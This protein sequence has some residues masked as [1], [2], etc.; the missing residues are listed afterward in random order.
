M[1]RYTG[2]VI[3]LLGC[4]ATVPHVDQPS[5]PPSVII[6]PAPQPASTPLKS[7]LAASFCAKAKPILIAKGD[8]M[9]PNIADQIV[10]HNKMG[11]KLCGWK[12]R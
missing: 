11:E 3:F 5:V 4:A 6:A 2:L 10:A 9:T 1:S 8:R 7:D 12:R